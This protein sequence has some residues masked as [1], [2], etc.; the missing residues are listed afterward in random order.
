MSIPELAFM[1]FVIGLTGALVPGLTDSN[2]QVRLFTLAGQQDPRSH[3]VIIT[4]AAIIVLIVAG[5]LH[6][7]Y[8]PACNLHAWW[9]CLVLFGGM[10]LSG[11]RE[12][13]FQQI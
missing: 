7:L 2:N 10:T 11:A 12:R 9:H 1:G 3:L 8:S 13:H 5:I 6:S 4:E